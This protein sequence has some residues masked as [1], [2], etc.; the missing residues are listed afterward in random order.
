M[1]I[2]EPVVKEKPFK[3]PNPVEEKPSEKEKKL[4]KESL[5]I[6]ADRMTLPDKFV[7]FQRL[8]FEDNSRV[9]VVSAE[10]SNYSREMFTV[11]MK[12]LLNGWYHVEPITSGRFG[13]IRNRNKDKP[14][15]EWI[16][17]ASERH[18]YEVTGIHPDDLSERNP[19]DEFSELNPEDFSGG[20]DR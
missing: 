3:N 17:S 16:R 14:K 19:E 9:A 6:C 10:V 15:K 8:D 7:N 13:V 20:G 18:T 1:S 5:E 4:I 11:L 12:W 2:P